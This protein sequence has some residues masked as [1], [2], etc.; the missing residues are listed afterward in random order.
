M[1]SRWRGPCRLPDPLALL[2]ALALTACAGPPAPPPAPPPPPDPRFGAVEA[3]HAP[4]QA[5]AA[6]VGWERI[7]FYWSEIERDG[8][9][10]WNWFHA[11]M[12][13][14]DAEIAAGREI[15]GLVAHTP[16]W[17]TDGLEGAGIPYGLYL[18]PDD[19]RNLW[20]G[21][22]RYLVT[23]YG[24]RVHR[25]IIWNEP[26]IAL[27]TFGA[28]WQGTAAD[29]YQ[30]VRTAAIVAREVDPAAQ[31]H[32]GGL[33]YWHNPNYLR[34]FLTAASA[35]PTAAASGYYFDAVS[36]HVYFKPET[37]I[38]IVG[39]LRQ[40]LADFGLDRP[41]W[42]NE[43]NAPPYDDPSQPWTEPVFRVTQE[44]QAAFLLQEFALALALGVERVG[45]YKWVDEPPPSPG[46]E[47]YGLL[48]ADRSPRPAYDA[49]RAAAAHYAGTQNAAYRL[50]PEALI[51]ALDRDEQ[52][53]R[54]VWARGPYRTLVALPALAGSARRVDPTGAARTI[55]PL[56]GHYWLALEPARCE[57]ECLMGGPPALII[58]DA[59]ADLSRPETFDARLAVDLT[60]RTRLA[61]AGAAILI[62]GAAAG[63][64][65]L[66]SRPPAG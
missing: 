63:L 34:E 21:Y 25:W 36:V 56:L 4:D 53:T 12:E 45:V 9:D 52:T 59:H 50:R 15:V 42:I 20:A 22:I 23:V 1:S 51:V 2:A 31:I 57:P 43:T 5:A 48:R 32:L 65:A 41:I 58:E 39:T 38:G 55:R 33:T 44:E 29:Y 64:A 35:D 11:P 47:P 13:R 62:A 16:G 40:T 30:L 60:P 54:V 18:P 6:G 26:D 49:Y 24:D 17:A 27:D 61:L 66:R 10:D 8:P 19:P 7:I 37:T 14:L 46:F 3:Y 28:Q